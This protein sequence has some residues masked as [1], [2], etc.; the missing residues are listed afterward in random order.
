[1]KVVK[2]IF[3]TEEERDILKKATEILD[4]ISE[5]VGDNGD[6]NLLSYR[7]PKELED[8]LSSACASC[9]EDYRNY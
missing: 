2:E 3:L 4:F 9:F 7:T 8:F 5:R 1:M 6:D